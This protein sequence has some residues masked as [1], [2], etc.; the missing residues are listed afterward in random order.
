MNTSSVIKPESVVIPGPS[1]ALEAAVE[2]PGAVMGNTVAIICHPHPLQ[3]GTMTNKVVTTLTRA[4]QA[5]GAVVI[6][7]NFRGVGASAGV[8]DNAVG[9]QE[10]LKAVMAWA[11]ER[12]PDCLF[13]LA[14]FSFGSYVATRVASQI[15]VEQLIAIAPPVNHFDFSSLPAI[16]CPWLVVQGEADEI[17]PATEVFAWLATRP[18]APHLIRMPGVGHF[19]HGKLIELREAIIDALLRGRGQV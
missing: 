6:R 9:E 5:L 4:C 15:H 13:W 2:Q 1:G 7:F 11:R 18:E 14:G 16:T 10:D 3:E 8:F 17:V 12:Y 19:F